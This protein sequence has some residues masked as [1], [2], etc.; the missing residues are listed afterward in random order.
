MAKLADPFCGKKED[1]RRAA[2]NKSRIKSDRSIVFSSQA[3]R[4]FNFCR[5][6]GVHFPEKFIFYKI[7]FYRDYLTK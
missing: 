2:T 1:G 4:C 5:L 7:L 6:Q 3:F